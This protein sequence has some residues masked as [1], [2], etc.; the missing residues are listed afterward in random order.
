MFLFALATRKL[1]AKFMT[2]YPLNQYKELMIWILYINVIS[3]LYVVFPTFIFSVLISAR[4]L[5]K[6]NSSYT[7]KL[8][9]IPF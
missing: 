3:Y 4:P 8:L 9:Q 2:L 1:T 7:A 5:K 6:K